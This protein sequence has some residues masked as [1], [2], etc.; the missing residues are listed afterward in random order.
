MFDTLHRASAIV[1]TAN[2]YIYNFEIKRDHLQMV[3]YSKIL[4]YK[5]L[6]LF[7]NIF[8]LI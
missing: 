1:E 5:S 4:I 2:N 7:W 8:L 6:T 3:V